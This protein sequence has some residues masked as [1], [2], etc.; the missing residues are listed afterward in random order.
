MAKVNYWALLEKDG[1]DFEVAHPMGPSREED[2]TSEGVDPRHMWVQL[3]D[4]DAYY[5][6]RTWD[7]SQG[8]MTPLY[9]G[10]SFRSFHYI[11]ATGTW[12]VDEPYQVSWQEVRDT[13]SA[14]LT[15]T[16]WVVVKYTELGEPL[17]A[18]WAT[19]RQ[20]LRDWPVTQK[21]AGFT[22][23]QSLENLNFHVD[24]YT[25]AFRIARGLPASPTPHTP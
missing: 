21:A 12:E 20:D 5:I 4:T 13:R 9:R 1:P 6:W 16:D 18:E 24:P 19:W 17:P 3:D 23:E 14:R 8:V 11:V 2:P 15:H 25:K 7:F 10:L 22:A